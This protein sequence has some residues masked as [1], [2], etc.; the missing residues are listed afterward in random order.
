MAMRCRCPGKSFIPR[1][2][3]TVPMP[4][5][6]ALMKIAAACGTDRAQHVLVGGV[7]FFDRRFLP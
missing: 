5:G 1:F 4:S 2:P 3:T 7:G 6:S